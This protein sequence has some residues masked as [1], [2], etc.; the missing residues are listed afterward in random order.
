MIK[1]KLF[2]LLESFTGKHRKGLADFV[3][4]HAN[5]LS[6]RHQAIMQE[7]L[8][9]LSVRRKVDENEIW[10]KVLREGESEKL[11]KLKYILLEV[12]KRYVLLNEMEQLPLKKNMI[13]NRYFNEKGLDRNLK[14]SLNRGLKLVE[15]KKNLLS[16]LKMQ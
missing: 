4:L 8:E 14:A 2:E 1:S 15:Q 13:L 12:T 10:Q 7:V 16:L 11:N 3:K 6:L 5:K 9:E